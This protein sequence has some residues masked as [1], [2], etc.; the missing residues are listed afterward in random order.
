[1][2][3]K[4]SLV[5]GTAEFIGALYVRTYERACVKAES[6]RFLTTI[7]ALKKEERFKH[8][9]E[10]IATTDCACFGIKECSCWMTISSVRATTAGLR[11]LAIVSSM[12]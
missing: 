10:A 3:P 6:I 9:F 11:R 12:I 4:K 7:L 5:V 1:L 2:S 8:G